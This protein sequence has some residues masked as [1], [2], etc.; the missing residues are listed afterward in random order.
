METVICRYGFCSRQFSAQLI[1]KF[2]FANVTKCLLLSLSQ[3]YRN[4]TVSQ[5]AK[6]Q[7]KTVWE[8]SAFWL[9]S[10]VRHCALVI[11]SRQRVKRY[12]PP[13]QS[14]VDWWRHCYRRCYPNKHACTVTPAIT[15]W[16]QFVN[17]F[18]HIYIN[19]QPVITNSSGWFQFIGCTRGG[20]FQTPITQ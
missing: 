7:Q 16:E 6:K 5:Y 10:W 2:C 3:P 14:P 1:I 9:P 4:F 18:N 11:N 20:A 19:T 15:N 8:F 17:T 12:I 13:P